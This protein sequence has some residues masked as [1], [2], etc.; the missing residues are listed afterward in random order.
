MASSIPAAEPEPVAIGEASPPPLVSPSSS[1]SDASPPGVFQK[2]RRASSYAGQW[3]AVDAK[4]TSC[5]IQLASVPVLDLYKASTTGCSDEGLRSVNAWS[6]R[7]D[8]VILFSRGNA[9]ARLSG[10]EASLS[11]T[12][13]ASGGSLKM[14][15]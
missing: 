1:P 14:V 10:E 4:G 5:K 12:L 8:H 3:K 13:S 6:L 2:P 9:I 15:R 7:E 11:G